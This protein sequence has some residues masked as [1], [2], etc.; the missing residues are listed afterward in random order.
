MKKKNK[1]NKN[2][3]NKPFIDFQF[4]SCGVFSCLT[5]HFLNVQ[6]KKR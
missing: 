4:N 6:G 2:R 1:K 3:I 5:H